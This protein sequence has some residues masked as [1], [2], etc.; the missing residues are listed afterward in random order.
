MA[1]LSE[2]ERDEALAGLDGWSFDEG[3]NGIVHVSR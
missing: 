1:V 3:R 2:I